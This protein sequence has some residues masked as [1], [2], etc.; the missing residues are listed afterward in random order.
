MSALRKVTTILG[1]GLGFLLVAVASNIAGW[2]LIL[3]DHR[4]VK[5]EIAIYIVG[6]PSVIFF[7]PAVL[8]PP[9]SFLDSTWGVV[10]TTVVLVGFWGLILRTIWTLIRRHKK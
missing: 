10:L 6:L 8:I 5:T 9:R 1:F 2:S 3:S 7:G 4:G